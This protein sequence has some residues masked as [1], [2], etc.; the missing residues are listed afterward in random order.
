V[1]GC[2]ALNITAH[3]AQNQARPGGS[4]IDARTV[5]YRGYAVSQWIRKQVEE[6]LTG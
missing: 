3:V 5:R 6:T 1:A 2:R 4:A